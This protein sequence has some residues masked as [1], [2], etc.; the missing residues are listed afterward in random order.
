M[1]LI[2]KAL[3]ASVAWTISHRGLW[4]SNLSAVPPLLCWLKPEGLP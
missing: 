3:M 1:N 2:N 4:A